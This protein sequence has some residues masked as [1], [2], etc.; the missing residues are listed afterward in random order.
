MTQAEQV[1]E[2]VLGATEN[3][4]GLLEHAMLIVHPDIEPMLELVDPAT[5]SL[6]YAADALGFAIAR[7]RAEHGVPNHRPR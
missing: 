7:Y 5:R 2:S 6:L 4:L 1:L 3:T